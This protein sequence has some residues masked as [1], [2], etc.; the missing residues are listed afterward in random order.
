MGVVEAIETWKSM[1]CLM[2]PVLRQ[3]VANQRV[4]NMAAALQ[5]LR[6]LQNLISVP[7]L[8][9]EKQNQRHDE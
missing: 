3:I 6:P 2:P 1:R 8:L 4:K 5:W 9:G 7:V